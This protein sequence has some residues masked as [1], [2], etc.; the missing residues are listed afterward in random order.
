MLQAATRVLKQTL[1]TVKDD[2]DI[3]LV[4]SVSIPLTENGHSPISKAQGLLCG[5]GLSK[6]L[7]TSSGWGAIVTHLK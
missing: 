3:F 4:R 2:I 1:F 6:Y 5:R 7:V